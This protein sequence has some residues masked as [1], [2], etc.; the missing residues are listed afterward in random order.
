MDII[1]FFLENVTK[2][3]S[4]KKNFNEIIE[5]IKEKGENL[6]LRLTSKYLEIIDITLRKT[7]E[8][9]QEWDIVRVDK[10]KIITEIGVVEFNRTYYR[11]K[12]TKKYI[13]LLDD[14]IGLKNYQRMTEEV[15]AKLL[16]LASEVSYEKAGKFAYENIEISKQTVM[17]KVK[18]LLLKEIELS[19]G[20]KKKEVKTLYI[21]ADEDHVTIRKGK[22]RI[23]KII[24]IY[25]GKYKESKER[26]ALY[27]KFYF[28]SYEKKSEDL[29]IDVMDYIYENYEL[30]KIENVFIQG[31]GANWIKGG[32]SWIDKSRY[33][34]DKF[35]L[36]KAIQKITKGKLT[37]GVGLEL[38]N[39]VYSLDKNKFNE[40]TEK[41][42]EEEKS[43]GRKEKLKKYRGYIRNKW[44]GIEVLVKE[45]GKYKLGC[46]AEGHVSHILS[47]RLSSRPMIWGELG[48][49]AMSRLRMLTANGA[50]REE[51][52]KIMES[53]N[54]KNSKEKKLKGRKLQRISKK[55]VETL[56][57]IP[58]INIGKNISAKNILKNLS[59]P[60]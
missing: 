41:M 9:K 24:Y 30:D 47:F 16:E 53:I 38:K 58:V 29:W 5:E 27:N 8:R 50:G 49:E 19:K 28:I 46:S 42:I 40:I 23:V 39:A 34:I 21:D 20:R 13:Y 37:E 26:M 55:I 43:E 56:G 57:N 18:K 44:K 36:N 60:I 1:Q 48:L 59:H 12:K 7:N 32:S 6:L 3:I 31:D 4:E 45:E 35:H 11:H 52:K 25:E 22:K 2:F 33:I 17:N 15:E 10:R 14:Y 54:M 51:L